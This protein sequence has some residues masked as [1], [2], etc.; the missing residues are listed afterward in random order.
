MRTFNQTMSNISAINLRLKPIFELSDEELR[1]RL[2][3][4]YE[5]VRNETFAKGGYLTYYD[6]SVCPNTSFAVHEYSDRKELMWMDKNYKEHFIKT[7]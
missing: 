1:E 6:P 2:R 5:A 7:L 3:P 4:T